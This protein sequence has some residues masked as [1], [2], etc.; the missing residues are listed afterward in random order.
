MMIQRLV[1]R[2]LETQVLTSALESQINKLLWK[3]ECDS[4]DIEALT[5][6]MSA[7]AD[8]KVTTPDH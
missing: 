7:I 1:E 6:L 8:G 4:E 5:Q 2:V 3:R